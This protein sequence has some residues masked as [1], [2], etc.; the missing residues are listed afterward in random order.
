MKSRLAVA[1]LIAMSASAEDDAQRCCCSTLE[2][3]LC[4]VKVQKK[5]DAELNQTYQLALRH[6]KNSEENASN[7]RRVERQWLFYREEACKAESD[8]YKGGSIAPQI[9]GFCLVKLTKRRIA[10]IKDAYLSN[11]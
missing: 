7:L 8:L 2:T 3:N 6:M 11:H 9:F 1:I 4:L 10:D 5:L